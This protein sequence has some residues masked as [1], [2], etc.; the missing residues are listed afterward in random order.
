MRAG[1][2]GL[3]VLLGGCKRLDDLG[4]LKKLLPK[5]AFDDVKVD[6]LSFTQVDGKL[7]LDLQNPY[8][9]SLRLTEASWKL[10]LAGHPFLDGTDRDGLAVDAGATS[11]LRIPFAVRFVDAFALATDL[12]D[13]ERMPFGGFT[14]APER[15]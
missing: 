4:D 9:V 7:L 3:L 12:G 2:V 5:V 13:V 10:G 11:K 8:P 1:W 6:D 14:A 15:L